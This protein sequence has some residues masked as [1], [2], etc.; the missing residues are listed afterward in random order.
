MNEPIAILTRLLS[1]V[2]LPNLKAVQVSQAEQIAANDRLENEIDELRTHLNS[3][4][5]HLAALLTACRAELATTQAMLK[6]TREQNGTFEPDR[7][8]LIH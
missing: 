5:A 4:F 8:T 3:Q 1:D 7:T 2:I 6:A